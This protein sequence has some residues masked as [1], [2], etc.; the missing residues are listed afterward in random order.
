VV[1]HPY[2]PR[3][4]GKGQ[5]REQLPDVSVVSI[6]PVPVT[7]P[8]SISIPPSR[9]PP[10]PY[11]FPHA[12]GF[13]SEERALIIRTMPRF[14][15]HSIGGLNGSAFSTATAGYESDPP[16]SLSSSL[17]H[18]ARASLILYSWERISDTTNT[19]RF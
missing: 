16:T 6:A 7:V 14:P 10:S 17:V 15:L 13:P 12:G 4:G 11:E 5:T 18:S 1:G 9:H 3:Q 2:L 8:A 19:S